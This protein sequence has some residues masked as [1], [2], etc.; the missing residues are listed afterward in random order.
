MCFKIFA[1]ILRFDKSTY[2]N[3]DISWIFEIFK[4]H[5]FKLRFFTIAIWNHEVSQKSEFLAAFK[6]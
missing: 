3:D 6:F 1:K 2:G 4:M 5:F